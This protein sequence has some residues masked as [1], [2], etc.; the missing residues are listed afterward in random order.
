MRSIIRVIDW[1]LR[2]CNGVFEFCGDPECVFRV[3][4]RVTKYP[5]R[6]RDGTIPVGTRVLELHFWNEHLPPMPGNG[7]FIGP[8]VKLRRRVAHSAQ[9]LAQAIESDP[10][11]AGVRA[12]GGV[13]PLFTAGDNSAAEGIFRR[14]GFC[15]TPHQNPLGRVLE[16]WEE[17]YAWSL[18]WAFTL[19]NQNRRSLRGLRRS[20]FWI[21]ADDFLGLYGGQ[22]TGTGVD[23]SGPGRAAQWWRQ[24]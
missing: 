10:R 21:C 5:L 7:S 6:V 23:D 1:L 15:V 12:V 20:D 24:P 13:T 2:K 16:F 14:L 9:R 8:A 17:V 4:V 11:L 22:P 18:M 3:S 19:E